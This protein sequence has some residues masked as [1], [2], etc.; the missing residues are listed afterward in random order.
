MGRF[1]LECRV[2]GVAFVDVELHVRHEAACQARRALPAPLL[3]PTLE[4]VIAYEKTAPRLL[5]YVGTV[6]DEAR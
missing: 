2:C 4:A 1:I 5:G 3:A 6:A